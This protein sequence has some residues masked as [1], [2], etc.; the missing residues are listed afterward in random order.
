MLGLRNTPIIALDQDTG[1]RTSITLRAIGSALNQAADHWQAFSLSDALKPVAVGI[2]S[3]ALKKSDLVCLCKLEDVTGLTFCTRSE[4]A[5]I[6][7]SISIRHVDT[8]T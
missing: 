7:M 4:T 5:W 8:Q 1:L 3:N 2:C 6:L